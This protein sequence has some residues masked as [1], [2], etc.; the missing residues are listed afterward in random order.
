MARRSGAR[1]MSKATRAAARA[2]EAVRDSGTDGRPSHAALRNSLYDFVP[3]TWRARR[4][5]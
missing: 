3:G 5:A 4:I 1:R 2:S